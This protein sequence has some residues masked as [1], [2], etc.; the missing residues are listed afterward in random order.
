MAL[1]SKTEIPEAK[2]TAK[3]N[4]GRHKTS[5]SAQENTAHYRKLFDS[6]INGVVVLDTKGYITSVNQAMT[7]LCGHPPAHFVGR[8]FS[9]VCSVPS[10][11]KREIAKL[12]GDMFRGKAGESEIEMI[13]KSGGRIPLGVIATPLMDR[14]RV[15]GAIAILRDL[16]ER[17]KAEAALELESKLINSTLDSVYLHDLSGRI[18]YANESMLQTHG[19]SGCEILK[20]RI[21]D[22]TDKANKPYAMPRIRRIC[23]KGY[24]YF[25]TAH[26]RKDGTIFPLEVHAR[27][28]HVNGR[29]T[30][31]VVARDI[32]ERKKAESKI[33]RMNMLNSLLN[34]C[35]EA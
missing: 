6:V 25:E 33:A 14:G 7:Q 3:K 15:R 4:T 19:Y 13:S 30:I 34:E 28:I 20:L 9:Q 32:T 16:R 21:Q 1:G 11:Q 8:H 2:R 5:I 17:K 31:L 29:K 27:S 22:I 35:H 24:L 12:F 18:L 10:A 23:L 26:V